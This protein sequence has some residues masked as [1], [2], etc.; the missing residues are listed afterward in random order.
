MKLML[1]YREHLSHG[2]ESHPIGHLLQSGISSTRVC[3]FANRCIQWHWLLTSMVGAIATSV[4]GAQLLSTSTWTHQLR[5]RHP[6]APQPFVFSYSN[7]WRLF[8]IAS[9]V[10]W[11]VAEESQPGEDLCFSFYFLF[12]DLASALCFDISKE[13]KTKSYRFTKW[14]TDLEIIKFAV[15]AN[16]K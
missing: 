11:Q 6:L 8:D 4:A 2:R 9:A 1:T 12:L 7:W 16:L 3:T 15:T 14:N 5:C 10:R 13:S